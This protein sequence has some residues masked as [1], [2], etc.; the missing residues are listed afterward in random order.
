MTLEAEI[1]RWPPALSGGDRSEAPPVPVPASSL[2]PTSSSSIRL[3]D[4]ARFHSV[5]K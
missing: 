1:W 4:D 3:L 5:C 2:Q